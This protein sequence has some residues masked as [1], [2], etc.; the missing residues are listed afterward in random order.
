MK[1]SFG[2]ITAGILALALL[3]GAFGVFTQPAKAHDATVVSLELEAL[4]QDDGAMLNY[5]IEYIQKD[6]VF[7]VVVHDSNKDANTAAVNVT[8]RNTTRGV[9]GTFSATES[10]GTENHFEVYVKVEEGTAVDNDP[11]G[12]D[13]DTPKVIPGFEADTISVSYTPF[14]RSVTVDNIGPII[15]NSTPSSA[16]VTRVGPVIFSADITDTGSGFTGSSS[17]IDDFAAKHGRL[18]LEL[19]G[20]TLTGS[21]LKY[22]KID[23]GWNISNTTSLGVSGESTPIPW[24]LKAVDRAGNETILDRTTATSQLTVD[25]AKPVLAASTNHRMGTAVP[26]AEEDDDQT[27]DVDESAVRMGSIS[28]QSRTGAKWD[29]SRAGGTYTLEV[30]DFDDDN[31]D[32]TPNVTQLTMDLMSDRARFGRSANSRSVMVLFHEKGGLNVD[33]VAPTDFLVGG[34]VPASVLVVDIVEDSK[35]NPSS[36]VR[37]PQEVFLTMTSG[38]ASNSK[39]SVTLSGSVQDVAGNTAVS[40]TIRLADGL[41]PRFTVT[42]NR[43]YDDSDVTITVTADETLL[44]AP[45][46]TLY[47]QK[48]SSSVNTDSAAKPSLTA[49]GA[50]SYERRVRVA[51]EPGNNQARK[52]L[53]Q[54]TG[55]DASPI[56]NEGT[57]GSTNPRSGSA[58]A[59]QLDHELNNSMDPEFTVAGTKILS[60]GKL[61]DNTSKDAEIEVVNPLLITVA[62]NRQCDSSGCAAGGE[63]TEYSGDTHRTVELTASEIKV[64]LSDGTSQTLSPSVSSTDNIVYTVAVANP[65]TGDYTLTLNGRDEAGNVSISPPGAANATDNRSQVRGGCGQ[66]GEPEAEPGLEPDLPPLPAHQPVHQLRHPGGPPHQPGALL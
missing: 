12:R 26:L 16:A 53:V 2:K 19:F 62:F 39:P 17:S 40:G 48:S 60:N 47:T 61:Q 5:N 21:D 20:A 54:V 44:S 25:G 51:H 38:L 46:L 6:Q 27:N 33:T 59:F 13:F 9:T 43:T 7:L 63:R 66:A 28:L 18:S 1:T 37:R 3:L 65:P 45:T 57:T 34:Q 10:G 15:S 36:S 50:L 64:T 22:T 24:E 35:V 49:T 56:A 32:Q 58:I 42:T 31:N 14:T 52:V 23:D 55:K 30:E 29:G 4:A 8:V 41:P 11:D